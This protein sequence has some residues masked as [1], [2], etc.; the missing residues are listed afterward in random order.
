MKQFIVRTLINALALMATATLV[1]GISADGFFGAI[2]AALV[3]GVVN[4]IIRPILLLFSLPLTI[5]TLGLFTFVVNGI[6]LL[7]VSTLVSGFAVDGLIAAILG[8][9]V[10]TII[11][12]ILTWLVK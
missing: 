6:V 12:S 10:M 1:N 5:M 8:S 4:A 3:L 7:I 9:V 2:I 11:S